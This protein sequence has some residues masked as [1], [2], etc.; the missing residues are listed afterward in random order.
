[1]SIFS[2]RATRCIWSRYC[3]AKSTLG[4]GLELRDSNRMSSINS[5]ASTAGSAKPGK[6]RRGGEPNSRRMQWQL[7]RNSQHSALPSV[8]H[9]TALVQQRTGPQGKRKTRTKGRERAI[10]KEG[11]E[12]GL[13]CPFLPF[14]GPDFFLLFLLAVMRIAGRC[15]VD[16]AHTITHAGVS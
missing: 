2:S 12:G 14:L 5:S 16:G 7:C 11:K 9:L 15:S 1:M 3:L 13:V 8:L 10:K 4:T 6:W